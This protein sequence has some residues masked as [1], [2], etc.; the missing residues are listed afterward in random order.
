[1]RTLTCDNAE[2]LIVRDL[3]EGLDSADQTRLDNH[4]AGCSACRQLRRQFKTL[5][6][7]VESDVPQD[8]G[9]EFWRMYDVSLEAKLREKDMSPRTFFGWRF[10]GAFVAAVAILL[11]ASLGV[12]NLRGPTTV[13]PTVSAAVMEDLTELYGPVPDEPYLFIGRRVPVES[14][15]EVVSKRTNYDDVVT[16]WFEVEDERNHLFL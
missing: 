7:S 10:A 8:P 9:E 1:M 13:D 4:L 14:I 16:T 12:I 15:A 11:A 6:A 3:D 5:F 2:K